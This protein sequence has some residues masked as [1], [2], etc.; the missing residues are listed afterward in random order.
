MTSYTSN[1]GI[2]ANCCPTGSEYSDIY[3]CLPTGMVPGNLQG[4][5]QTPDLWETMFNGSDSWW[6]STT[7]QW[8]N[9]YNAAEAMPRNCINFRNRCPRKDRIALT[10]PGDCCADICASAT[11]DL[12]ILNTVPKA[13]SK[14]VTVMARKGMCPGS[15][16]PPVP[17]EGLWKV[18]VTLANSTLVPSDVYRFQASRNGHSWVTF[19]SDYVDDPGFLYNAIFDRANAPCPTSCLCLANT[20]DAGVLTTFPDTN[21]FWG[22]T[23]I[24]GQ[25][26]QPCKPLYCYLRIVAL[27][28]FCV[29]SFTATYASGTGLCSIFPTCPT[30]MVYEDR[31]CRP[32]PKAGCPGLPAPQV[33]GWTDPTNPGGTV[34]PPAISLDAT[35]NRRL[36]SITKQIR[37]QH[38]GGQSESQ[39][40]RNV[41]AVAGPPWNS[42]STTDN[43]QGILLTNCGNADCTGYACPMCTKTLA[44]QCGVGCYSNGDPY[45]NATGCSNPAFCRR[46]YARK[47]QYDGRM[48]DELVACAVAGCRLAGNQTPCTVLQAS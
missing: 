47:H 48:L 36:L 7:N 37:K 10:L 32:L 43:G 25:P 44:C 2:N 39:H 14:T 13:E 31:I 12:D 28:T 34:V 33:R 22:T 4:E 45:P 1:F 9:P 42:R 27:S 18:T 19:P 40:T 3:G 35:E 26:R 21:A 29:E 8:A 30:A 6:N 17:L 5:T 16:S 20:P 11:E 24:N 38:P 41:R 46:R 15:V 23:A